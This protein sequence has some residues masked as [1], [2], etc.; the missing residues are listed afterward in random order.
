MGWAMI[1][2]RGTT[3]GLD[4]PLD[5]SMWLMVDGSGTA[6]PHHA[7]LLRDSDRSAS[8]A[9]D[10]GLVV[11]HACASVNDSPAVLTLPPELGHLVPGDIVNVTADGTKVRVL[12]RRDGWPNSI[13]LTERC[14]NYCLMCS[15]PPRDVDDSWLLGRAHELIDMLPITTPQ[16]LFTGGEPTIY[17]KGFLDLMRFTLDRL[18]ASEVHILTNGRKF[19]DES[20]ARAYA[21]VGDPRMMVG[22]PLYGAERSLHDF[23]VQADGVFDE[24]VRGILNLAA[25]CQPIEIRVVVHKQTAPAI[26]EIAEFIARNLPFVD[27]VALMGLEMMGLARANMS[28]VWI[29][30]WDYRDELA[31]AALLL[32][33]ARI[34][35]LIFNHQLCLLDESVWHLAVPSISDWKNVYLPEC[36]GCAVRQDCGGFFHSSKYRTSDHIRAVESP[37]EDDASAQLLPHVGCH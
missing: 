16:I 3:T 8:R 14:D 30:P 27:Q 17:G 23:V 5:R 37:A 31:E 25:L 32:E 7:L 26:V 18:P 34:R 15:Q 36:D 9:G 12:W 20:F 19:S 11:R 35:T 6:E 33:S 28:D 4:R 24:T 10:Y 21:E 29:D 2:L 22:I 13:L 1:P